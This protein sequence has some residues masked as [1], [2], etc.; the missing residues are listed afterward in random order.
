MLSDVQPKKVRNGATQQIKTGFKWWLK[1]ATKA[2]RK[3]L[4]LK[5]V[6][7]KLLGGQH[8]PRSALMPSTKL[9]TTSVCASSCH[10]PKGGVAFTIQA[11]AALQ[12]LGAM[13]CAIH[14]RL[15]LPN[16]A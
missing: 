2:I 9:C 4:I 5:K 6:Y 14:D 13:K 7:K 15:L 12:P 8:T 16:C 10:P 11:D 1:T 3:R